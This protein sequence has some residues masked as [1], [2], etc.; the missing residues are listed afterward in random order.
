ME[1]E[2]TTGEMNGELSTNGEHVETQVAVDM[3]DSK[4]TVDDNREERCKEIPGNEQDFSGLNILELPPEMILRIFIHVDIR[5][6]FKTVILTCKAF[7]Q[8]LTATDIWKTIFALKWEQTKIHKDYEYIKTWRDVYFAYDDINNFWTRKDKW[9]L[10]CKKV[11]GHS[12]TVDAVHIMP[13]LNFAVSGSRDRS[14]VVW[15]I[16]DFLQGDEKD[17]EI[18]EAVTLLGHK[19]SRPQG[20]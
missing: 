5:T 17:E 10:Q 11:Q 3:A 20:L 15:D 6:I 7:H 12:A 8:I 18:K 4:L 2:P 16:R 14:A 13:G 19:V 9:A 1:G